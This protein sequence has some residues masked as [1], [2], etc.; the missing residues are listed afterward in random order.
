MIAVATKIAPYDIVDDAHR[1][2]ARP[3]LP[4][5]EERKRIL[6]AP[7]SFNVFGGRSHASGGSPYAGA[8]DG[9]NQ[10]EDTS[11]RHPQED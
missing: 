1:M 8:Y 6:F 10:E 11:D 9:D 7:I 2:A 3:T 4:S 5:S